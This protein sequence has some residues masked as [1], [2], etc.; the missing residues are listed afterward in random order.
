[1]VTIDGVSL[2][3]GTTPA[4]NT[5]VAPSGNAGVGDAARAQLECSVIDVATGCSGR[6]VCR[7]RCR[8]PGRDHQLR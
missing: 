3:P 4:G 7:N 2:E 6:R 5:F 8:L 1:V